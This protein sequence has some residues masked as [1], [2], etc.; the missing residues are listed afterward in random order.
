MNII[1]RAIYNKLFKS[2]QIMSDYYY[3]LWYKSGK[4][5][6]DLERELNKASELQKIMDHIFYFR[7]EIIGIEKN[8]KGTTL[9]VTKYMD[10]SNLDIYLHGQLYNNVIPL[11][12]SS[13]LKRDKSVEIRIDEVQMIDNSIG[14]GTIAMKYFLEQARKIGCIRIFGELSIEDRNN[15]ERS[16]PY[17]KKFGFDVKLNEEGTKGSINLLMNR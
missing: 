14:N 4:K 17:Y 15:F 9:L 6:A 13:I 12:Q 7:R 11:I 3:D 10:T 2:E 8:R 1:K 5:T 16:I